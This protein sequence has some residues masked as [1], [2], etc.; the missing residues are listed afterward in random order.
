MHITSSRCIQKILED[1]KI[2]PSTDTQNNCSDGY[3]DPDGVDYIFTMFSKHLPKY[4]RLNG[5]YLI[6]DKNLV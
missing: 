5:V 4:K 1:G 3:S 2:I 6:F